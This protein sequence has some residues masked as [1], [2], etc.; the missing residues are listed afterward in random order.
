MTAGIPPAGVNRG[1]RSCEGGEPS[2]GSPSS[3]TEIERVSSHPR[4]TDRAVVRTLHGRRLVRAALGGE[5]G[6]DSRILTPQVPGSTPGRGGGASGCRPA[7]SSVVRAGASPPTLVATLSSFSLSRSLDAL[8]LRGE[9]RRAAHPL[10]TTRRPT[11][12]SAPEGSVESTRRRCQS[13]APVRRRLSE[14]AN[15]RCQSKA[16]IECA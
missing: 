16:S 11:S 10:P 13:K 8:G 2:R 1:E 12:S 5:C 14:S 3:L 15:R 9:C 4:L 7:G 6:G